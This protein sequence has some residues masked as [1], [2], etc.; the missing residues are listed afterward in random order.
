MAA[1]QTIKMRRRIGLN[2]SYNEEAGKR[3]KFLVKYYSLATLIS[4]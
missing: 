3:N 1:V 4:V 2:L